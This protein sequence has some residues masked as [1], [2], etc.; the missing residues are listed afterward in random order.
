MAVASA[1]VNNP[2][3]PV[4]Y[5]FKGVRFPSDFNPVI[6]NSLKS[7]A[8]EGKSDGRVTM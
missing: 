8:P 6:E 1:V 2:Y 4:D 5:V 7:L 3:H